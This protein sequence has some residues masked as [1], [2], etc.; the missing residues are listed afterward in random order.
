MYGDGSNKEELYSAIDSVKADYE[1]E[2]DFLADLV[3]IVA[4][5]LE[6]AGY[7]QDAW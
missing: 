3:S 7:G 1:N 2:L 4:G 5:Y 6:R